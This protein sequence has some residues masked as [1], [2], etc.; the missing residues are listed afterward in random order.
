MSYP[1]VEMKVGDKVFIYMPSAANPRE[2]VKVLAFITEL[3]QDPEMKKKGVMNLVIFPP[4][5]VMHTLSP[6]SE[7]PK[8]GHWGLV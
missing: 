2:L 5:G 7:Q 8:M 6:Y 4:Q 1:Q 3:P